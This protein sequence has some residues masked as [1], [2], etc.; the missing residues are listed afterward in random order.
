MGCCETR[1]IAYIKD[2][3]EKPSS[4]LP[5]HTDESEVSSK[6][7]QKK[8]NRFH[9]FTTSQAIRPSVDLMPSDL[10]DKRASHIETYC[11]NLSSS[12]SWSVQVDNRDYKIEVKEGSIF[13]EDI[14]VTLSYIDFGINV[15]TDEILVTLFDPEVRKFWDP[16]I[17]NMRI[18]NKRTASLFTL[19]YVYEFPMKN[20]DFLVKVSIQQTES[21]TVVVYYTI[22]S[23]EIKETPDLVRGKTLF[24]YVRIIQRP[25]TTVMMLMKQEDY[26]LGKYSGLMGHMSSQFTMWINFFRNAVL[27]YHNQRLTLGN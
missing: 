12:S 16:K 1:Y 10:R 3:K 6:N 18:L 9:E 20:R 13:D 8:D 25:E 5:I 19:Y 4:G 26:H 14:P 17:K 7:S 15:A 2:K 24:G 21:E 22:N 27:Q 11:N 23:D